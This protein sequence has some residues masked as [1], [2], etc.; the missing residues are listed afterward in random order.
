MCE[1]EAKSPV[2]SLV[3]PTSKNGGLL[4]TTCAK[5]HRVRVANKHSQN[6]T[7]SCD[8]LPPAHPSQIACLSVLT[9]I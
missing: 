3:D 5:A 6:G 9:P 2:I 1:L 4:R 7:K 8:C